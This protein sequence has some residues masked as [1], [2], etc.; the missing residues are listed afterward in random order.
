MENSEEQ[1]YLDLVGKVLAQGEVRE[2]RTGV[3]TLALFGTTMRFNLRHHFPL[4]TTKRMFWKGV[5]EELLWFLRGDTNVF[6][7]Q[8]KGVHIWDANV[9]HSKHLEEGDA[10]P[11]YGFQW[12]HFNAPY[13]GMNVDYTNEGVDQIQQILH[14]LQTNPFDRRMILTAWN[15]CANSQMV[16][17][18]CH[19]MCQFYVT[20]QRELCCMLF[21]RSGDLGLGVPFN[22]ASYSLLTH[23]M[24][25]AV[26]FTPGEFIH[27]IGDSHVYS[28]HRCGLE[29]Q[30]ARTPFPFPTLHILRSPTSN[31]LESL[32]SIHLED[33]QLDS[34]QCFPS[35]PMPMAV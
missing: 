8:E 29:I 21:Q 4:L 35:V 14:I 12:R 28:T 6:H 15:P 19:C 23:L 22:I 9:A 2:E 10:G 7:L 31:P 25:W 27:V 18:P 20:N 3:G 30:R 32:L 17:P 5:V 34:Y 33:L 26:G 13:R 24:A 11:I 16:L 1:Q